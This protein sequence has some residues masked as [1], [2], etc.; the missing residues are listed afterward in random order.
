MTS[1]NLGQYGKFFTAVAGLALTVLTQKYGS[2]TWLPY[3]VA[4]ASALGVYGVANTPKTLQVK[5]EQVSTPLQPVTL[6]S[7]LSDAE[8]AA[9]RAKLAELYPA[10]VQSTGTMSLP[11]LQVQQAQGDFEST[12][13]QTQPVSDPASQAGQATIAT[14]TA[15]KGT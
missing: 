4:V 7:Q 12:P 6:S 3:V 11:G 15:N 5:G 1:L 14:E 13:V 9:I 10:P 8:V 2:A